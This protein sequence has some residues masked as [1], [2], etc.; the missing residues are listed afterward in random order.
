MTR[1]NPFDPLYRTVGIAGRAFDTTARFV[2]ETTEQAGRR[3]GDAT[4]R[5]GRRVGDATE[6]VGG[7]I[8]D[9]TARAGS[10]L[11]GGPAP[12]TGAVD[13]ADRG[14]E[15][16]VTTDLPGFSPS[17][18]DTTLLSGETLRIVAE[19]DGTTADD[20]SGRERSREPVRR[21]V[22]L[23][24]YVAGD[25]TTAAYEDGVLTVTVPKADHELPVGTDTATVSVENDGTADEPANA[26]I[27]E[28]SVETA[29][30]GSVDDLEDALAT[31]AYDDR[32]DAVAD[33]EREGQD[34]ATAY[35]AIDDRREDIRDTTE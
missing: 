2:E 6:R 13:I 7:R 35:D 24:E 17:D 3:T 26:S 1:M 8:E 20:S 4:E 28:S 30:A 9:T 25:E 15:F 31:G 12:G 34:R 33:A 29:V 16:V 18:I 22:A 23:P 10:Q 14:D 27:D 11:R 19:R 21:S 32:L 5:A